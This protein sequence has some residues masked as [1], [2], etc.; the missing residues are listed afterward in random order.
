MNQRFIPQLNITQKFIGFLFA[1]SIIPLLVVGIIS[2]RISGSILRETA[3]RSTSELVEGQRQYLELQLRQ[4][5]SLISNI[6]GVE[7]ITAALDDLDVTPDTYSRL[8]T[9]A[10]IGYILTGYTSLEGLVS[11]DIFSQGGEHYHVGDTLD[12]S[13]INTELKEE[14]Y[15][16]VLVSQ[17]RVNWFGIEDN[18]NSNSNHQKVITAATLLSKVS[19]ETL[20]SQPIALLMVNYSVDYLYDHFSEV[21]LGSNGYL[22][23][24]DAQNRIIYHPD[25][26]LIGTQAIPS[27]MEKISLEQGTFENIVDETNALV[28]YEKSKIS[29]WV[30]IGIVPVNTLLIGSNTIGMTTSLTILISIVLIA[31]STLMVSKTM[32]QP[33]REITTRFRLFQEGG[34]GWET[35]L[36][37]PNQRDEIR[38]MV[39]WFNLFVENL[40]ERKKA[41]ETVREMNA[42]LEERVADRTAQLEKAIQEL[43]AFSYSVSHDLRAPLRAING[44]ASILEE[45]LR[46]SLDEETQLYLTRIRKSSEKMDILI[47]G[48]LL[49]S[50]LGNNKIQ[51]QEINLSNLAKNI[52]ESISEK[53]EG[54]EIEIIVKDSS[55]INADKPLMTI[56]LTNLF[57]NALKFTRHQDIAQIEF[58]CFENDK[59]QG[60]YLKDNGIGFNMTHAGKIFGTFERIHKDESIEGTGIGLAIANRIVQRHQGEIWAESEE[61]KGATFYFTL[62]Q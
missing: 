27:L 13:T 62:N 7:T 14:I 30:V 49:L 43:E 5:E 50:R 15:N 17:S 6:S 21:D 28:S 31:L 29:D 3:T 26:E 37:L 58:G 46:D 23:V 20:E 1:I 45:E 4:V 52:F 54:R 9:Q 47:N 39:Q 56:L 35:Y 10:Q 57:A 40:E 48:L 51:L 55:L 42:T 25:K 53:E 44:Y 60:F 11:I 33:L 22:L 24:V 12:V 32:V 8:T 19:P 18:I 36:P 38:E 41:E 16:Q 34:D 59:Q 61:G 2:Y